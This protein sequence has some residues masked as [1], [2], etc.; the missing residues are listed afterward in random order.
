MA[1]IKH[2]SL[3]NLYHTKA[4]WGDDVVD[5]YTGTIRD[6]E[7]RELLAIID[8]YDLGDRLMGSVTNMCELLTQ[9]FGEGEDDWHTSM[10]RYLKFHFPD[11]YCVLKAELV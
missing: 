11:E 2:M 3:N 9:H 4:K 5:Y 1:S 7:T 10:R 8:V 6:R